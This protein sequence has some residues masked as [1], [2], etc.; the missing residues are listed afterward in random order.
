IGYLGGHKTFDVVGLTTKEEAPYWVAGAGSRF[1]HYE[2]LFRSSP[3][4][5]PT[6]F[7]VYRHWMACDA[8]LGEELHEET[9]T[10]QTILGGATIPAYA[11]RYDRLGSG[12]LPADGEEASRPVDELDVADLESE[13]THAYEL[14][15]AR[16]TDDVVLA[17]AVG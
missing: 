11:A 3:E 10:D 6:H 12:D 7:I 1:E 16:D 5:L 4:R 9:V 17:H 2:R 13:A 8:V 15:P 14:G